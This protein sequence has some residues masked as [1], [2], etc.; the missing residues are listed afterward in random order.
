MD[1]FVTLQPD[2]VKVWYIKP[3]MV[4]EVQL[5][6]AQLSVRNCGVVDGDLD[7]VQQS[8]WGVAHVVVILFG[9][10]NCPQYL[11]HGL[12]NFFSCTVCLHVEG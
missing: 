10:D 1:G 4:P 7:Y 12:V 8:I 6:R 11:F 2:L 9:Q 3:K 5:E